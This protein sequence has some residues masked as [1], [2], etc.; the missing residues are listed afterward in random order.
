MNP[1]RAPL[2]ASRRSSKR[3]ETSLDEL[4]Q[5]VIADYAATRALLRIVEV[6]QI[7]LFLMTIGAATIVPIIIDAYM[8]QDIAAHGVESLAG[9]VKLLAS[10]ALNAVSVFVLRMSNRL[11]EV[12]RSYIEQEF[13]LTRQISLIRA[14]RSVTA[15]YRAIVANGIGLTPAVQPV[16]LTA[17]SPPATGAS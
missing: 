11:G 7:A 14:C 13:R 17:G 2:T 16:S 1:E 9:V 3:S 15:V 10:G 12:T 6:P 8:I 5:A 4:K